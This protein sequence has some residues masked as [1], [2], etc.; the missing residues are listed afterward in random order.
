MNLRRS[1]TTALALATVGAAGGFAAAAPGGHRQPAAAKAIVGTRHDHALGTFLING[2][3][4]RT[5]Y[6]FQKDRRNRSRCSATCASFWPP[7][8][9]SG[10]PHAAGNA[11]QH[12]LGRIRRGSSWQVTYDGHPLYTY[13]G[14]SKAGQTNGEGLDAFGAR[15][16]VINP[17]GHEIENE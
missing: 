9:T 7:L 12:E 15:W 13:S 8:M 14:D 16:F 1:G 17:R 5:L 3:N 2:K 6:L 10:R 4:G 11:K